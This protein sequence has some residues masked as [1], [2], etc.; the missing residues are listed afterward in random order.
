MKIHN[1]SPRTILRGV[2]V[3]TGVD[4]S[5]TPC[6]QIEPGQSFEAALDAPKTQGP[7]VLGLEVDSLGDTLLRPWLEP[8]ALRRGG[9]P[10]PSRPRRFL[11]CVLRDEGEPV[12]VDARLSSRSRSITLL[13]VE[14]AP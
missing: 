14:E 3:Q 6:P 12:S 8:I 2:L 13:H 1:G 7:D 9:D 5:M 11:L 4:S 10:D